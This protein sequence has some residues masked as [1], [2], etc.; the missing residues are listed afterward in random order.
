[1]FVIEN[2]VGDVVISSAGGHPYDFDLV[3]A[4]KAIIPATEAVRRNGVIILCGAC[5]DGLGAE[6]TFI[7]WLGNKTP[8]EVVRDDVDDRHP[9]IRIEPEKCILC[10]RCARVTRDR[11]RTTFG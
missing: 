10:G 9:F 5:P 7:D 6:P 4:K 11:W 3:Q 1:M 2:T 8:G